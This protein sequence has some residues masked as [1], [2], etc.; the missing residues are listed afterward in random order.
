MPCL[1]IN[2]ASWPDLRRAVGGDKAMASVIIDARKKAP[3]TK[4]DF[5][6]L[7]PEMKHLVDDFD[8]A[9][10]A[11]EDVDQPPGGS[12]VTSAKDPPTTAASP[13]ASP[14]VAS[15][16]APTTAATATT[17]ATVTTAATTAQSKTTK[18]T[19]TAT[20]STKVKTSQTAGDTS[21]T[22]TTDSVVRKPSATTSTT[23]H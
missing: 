20:S 13:T 17:A 4:Q 8:Y 12:L 23:P 11:P 1:D 9:P 19:T 6:K 18:T 22:T 14:A 16:P 7:L 2:Q 3:I 21:T 5:L 15:P 10:E